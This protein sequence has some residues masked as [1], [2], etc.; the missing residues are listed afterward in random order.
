MPTYT[1]LHSSLFTKKFLF[2]GKFLE[3]VAS[4]GVNLSQLFF[5]YYELVL[6]SK[7]IQDIR[8]VS[9]RV[10]LDA[11]RAKTPLYKWSTGVSGILYAIMEQFEE[12]QNHG[13]VVRKGRHTAKK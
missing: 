9:R 6:E 13:A 5:L 2:A 4:Y 1:Q 12:R 10:L 8:Q 11:L 3:D 7:T